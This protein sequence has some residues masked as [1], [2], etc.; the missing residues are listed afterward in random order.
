MTFSS[1]VIYVLNMYGLRL[2]G[3]RIF[4]SE[5]EGVEFDGPECEC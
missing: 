3:S 2:T 5:A 4:N 1:P